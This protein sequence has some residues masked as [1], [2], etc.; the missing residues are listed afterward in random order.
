MYQLIRFF[1][2]IYL[3]L[4]FRFKVYGK[5]NVPETGNIIICGNHSSNNDTLMMAMVTKRDIHY[6]AKEELFKNPILK[7]V[8]TKAHAIPVHRDGN[9]MVAIRSAIRVLSNGEVLGIFPQG[10]RDKGGIHKEDSFKTGVATI[11]VKTK[12]PV[13]PV[14]I[15]EEYKLF[16]RNCI[17]VGEPINT[18]ENA[19]KRPT[20]EDYDEIA[21]GVIKGAIVALEEKWKA[22]QNK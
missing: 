11:S 7:W 5:E 4:F 8:F 6:M 18:W 12:S 20:P 15:S 3:K 22:E 21:N 13:I 17:Y 19:P 1:S 9:D 10:T 2:V 16:G 14:Y